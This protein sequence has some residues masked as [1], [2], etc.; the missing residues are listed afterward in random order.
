MKRNTLF[1]L[2]TVLL[3]QSPVSSKTILNKYHVI[4]KIYTCKN[5]GTYY[6][7]P[8]ISTGGAM[9]DIKR[10]ISDMEPENIGNLNKKTIELYESDTTNNFRI[11][12]KKIK[13]YQVCADN[14]TF[15]ILH[16]KCRDN[17]EIVIE[18]RE[19]MNFHRSIWIYKNKKSR[20]LILALDNYKI[21][22]KKTSIE[23]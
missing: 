12:F 10:Y 8:I 16:I 23:I 15:N 19:G 4:K 11:S 7:G 14:D 21:D 20:T 13:A 1:I 18:L 17:Y 2:F 6:C 22:F 3:I 5:L 9:T